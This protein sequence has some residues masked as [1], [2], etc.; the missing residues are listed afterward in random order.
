MS[1]DNIH[2]TNIY[3]A[4]FNLWSDLSPPT[5]PSLHSPASVRL[6]KR[7]QKGSAPSRSRLVVRH[8]PLSSAEFRVQRYRERQLEPPGE[9]PED[10]DDE[11]EEEEEGLPETAGAA[12]SDAGTDW[13]E[14][15]GADG[16]MSPLVRRRAHNGYVAATYLISINMACL[17]RMLVDK[18][19]WLLNVAVI[20]SL[21]CAAS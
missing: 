4:V 6:S 21:C 3:P 10:E 16:L 1:N 18:S 8:R 15:G 13:G 14:E 19:G 12:D 2:N 9:E 7:R 17:K 5:S 11:D 20:T